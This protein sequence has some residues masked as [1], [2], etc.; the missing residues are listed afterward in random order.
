MQNIHIEAELRLIV[1]AKSWCSMFN[2]WQ[3][4]LQSEIVSRQ[5]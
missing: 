1:D 5:N 2:K 4:Q 3:T